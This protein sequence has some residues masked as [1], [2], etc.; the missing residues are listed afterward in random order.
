MRTRE[1]HKLRGMRT[2]VRARSGCRAAHKMPKH[3]KRKPSAH[4]PR[5]PRA[6]AAAEAA[7]LAVA[8]A[9]GDGDAASGDEDDFDEARAID[10]ATLPPLAM[11]DFEQCDVKRCTGRKLQRQ[12]V[13][14]VLGLS[15]RFRGVVLSPNAQSTVSPADAALV[16]EF[17]AAVIDC[18]WAR[19]AEVPFARIKAR[20]E[21]LLPYLVAANSVN[22]GRPMK[23]SCVEALAA[24]LYI[25]SLKDE[26]R[27]LLAPF[28]WGAEF[29]KINLH[30]LDRYAA[31]ASSAEV[32]AAQ[33][34]YLRAVDDARAAKTHAVTADDPYGVR[35]L[36]PPSSSSSSSGDDIA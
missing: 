25:A 28:S 13:L 33:N 18:S 26:A 8:D 12:G 10:A 15:D 6:A 36:M 3:V 2:C 16:R 4:R 21:R 7:H 14:R 19:L 9:G 22:Y 32:I 30:L 29:V 31:C 1:L 11:W 20:E 17:G 27:K 5:Q 35:A 23:L 34:D 24:T